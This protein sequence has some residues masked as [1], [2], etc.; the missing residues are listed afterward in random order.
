M[1]Q[2]KEA[3]TNK[4]DTDMQMKC[5]DIMHKQVTHMSVLLVEILKQGIT[6]KTENETTKQ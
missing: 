4:Y 1:D 6:M 2:L 5:I 3:K